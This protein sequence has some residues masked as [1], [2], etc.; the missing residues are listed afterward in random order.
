MS[1]DILQGVPI[2]THSRDVPGRLR[3]LERGWMPSR[4]LGSAGSPWTNLGPLSRLPAFNGFR[5]RCHASVMQLSC[6]P[7]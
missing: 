4:A 1:N 7:L 2:Y 6:L 3:S 5:G